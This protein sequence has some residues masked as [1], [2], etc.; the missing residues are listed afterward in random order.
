VPINHPFPLSSSE[1][2]P[3][4]ASVH[5]TVHHPIP[6]A[7]LEGSTN[8][9]ID[10]SDSKHLLTGN[11]HALL[12][13]DMT[14]AATEWMD[15]IDNPNHIPINILINI[16]DDDEHHPRFDGGPAFLMSTGTGA[17]ATLESAVEYKLENGADPTTGMESNPKL[18][19]GAQADVVININSH[20]LNSTGWLDPNPWAGSGSDPVPADKVDM[21]SELAHEFGHGLGIGTTS[22]LTT[23]GDHRNEPTFGAGEK[24]TWES[25]LEIE[26]SSTGLEDF[27]HP[28]HPRIGQT[29]FTG[30]HAE[31]EHGGPV[32]V[33]TNT[34]EENYG[35]LGNTLSEA[36]DPLTGAPDVMYGVSF[37]EGQRYEVSDLD[38]AILQDLGYHT[39]GRE[40][41]PND[42]YISEIT[43][44]TPLGETVPKD[45]LIS[46]MAH[47]TPFDI[48]SLA[49]SGGFSTAHADGALGQVGHGMGGNIFTDNLQRAVDAAIGQVGDASGHVGDGAGGNIFTD[50]LQRAV[51][52]AIGQ[53]GHGE[54]GNI[55][56]DNLAHAVDAVIGQVG[57]GEGGP[58]ITDS[59]QGLG[60]TS[61]DWDRVAQAVS[62]V[63]TAGPL[64]ADAAPLTTPQVGDLTQLD[65]TRHG[66]L[67]DVVSSAIHDPVVMQAP[68]SAIHISASDVH[69]DL[70]DHG[71]AS[72]AAAVNPQPLP[73]PDVLI[74]YGAVA[75]SP[76]YDYHLG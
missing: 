4:G 68:D 24:T 34:P 38:V 58:A 10:V 61:I 7:V 28:G 59:A 67:G 29:Y 60:S 39:K 49:G 50:N 19:D 9:D 69:P 21:V 15:H 11:Q 35:H 42:T 37:D 18:S 54:G 8:L 76:H 55:F 66:N 44:P 13:A 31:K 36:T 56:T 30:S 48:H 12:E 5:D 74:D 71:M 63:T 65:L 27:L 23:T 22:S 1:V 41:V 57:H 47:R 52:A 64:A 46:E 43:H 51:D 14:Q 70:Q 25:L 53:V 40:T 17:N 73:A 16:T 26:K 2:V 72:A 3:V 20:Y 45:T 75:A 62:H 6:H 33:T 32:V